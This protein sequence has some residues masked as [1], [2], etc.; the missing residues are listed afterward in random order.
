MAA[1]GLL[2]SGSVV[3]D[4]LEGAKRLLCSTSQIVACVEADQCYPVMG[5]EAGVPDFIVVDIGKKLLSTT[6][7]SEENRVT[8][9]SSVSRANGQIYLQ[10]IDLGRAFSFVIHE[11]TGRITVAVSR[12]GV[13]V[14]VFG[15]C[16]NADLS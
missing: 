13:S 8:P 5:H 11:Q 6:K 7:A 3:A 2:I 15:A 4:N 14:T 12:D 9:I 1:V 16:T 10:G